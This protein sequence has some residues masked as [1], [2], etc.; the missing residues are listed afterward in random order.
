MNTK[1]G[2]AS[3]RLGIAKFTAAI[4]T[5][6]LFIATA[7]AEVV[8]ST[9]NASDN[10]LN[11]DFCNTGSTNAIGAAECTLRAAIQTLNQGGLPGV[12]DFAIPSDADPGCDAVTKV[13]TLARGAQGAQLPHI[14]VPITISGYSQPEA[15]RNTL[16]VGSNAN[17]VIELKNFSLELDGSDSLVE[18]LVINNFG[19]VWLDSDGN[20]VRGNYIGTD[21]T[22][23]IA[24]PN[25]AGV[26]VRNNAMN[27]VV[28]GLSTEHRNII[29][30]NSGNGI[31]ACQPFCGGNQCGPE[32]G[33]N[34]IVGNYIGVD[35]TGL[36]SLPN[37]GTGVLLGSYN[38]TVRDNVIA[39]NRSSGISLLGG[40]NIVRG[41]YIGVAADGTTALGNRGS[42][43]VVNGNQFDLDDGGGG[44]QIGGLLAED[45]NIIANSE[46]AEGI[47]VGGTERN[48]ANSILSNSIYRNNALGIDLAG[49]L[50]VTD[51]DPGDADTGANN[52]Q[53]FP[54]VTAAAL[55]D[56]ESLI[57]GTLNSTPSTQFTLQFFANT[58]CNNDFAP[59]NHG[60]GETLLGTVSVT[61]DANG[62]VTFSE[63]VGPAPVGQAVVTATAT[64][65]DGNTSEFSE[66]FNGIFAESVDLQISKTPDAD[67]VIVGEGVVYT[68]VVSHA[69]DSKDASGVQITDT[70]PAG[71]TFVSVRV[72]QGPGFCVENAG[73]I[74]CDVGALPDGQSSVIELQVRA[75]TAATISNE[76]SVTSTEPDKDVADNTAST[77]VSVVLG[78][79]TVTDSIAPIDDQ[80]IPFGLLFAQEMRSETVT[81]QNNS[82]ATVTL[83]AVPSDPLAAPFSIPDWQN[84]FGQTLAPFA[85]CTMSVQFAPT[86]PGEAYSSSFEIGFGTSSALVTVSGA[87]AAGISDISVQKDVDKDILSTDQDLATFTLTVSNVGP[88]PADIR[89]TDALPLSQLQIP[90]G[91]EPA[92]DGVGVV[93]RN[94]NEVVWNIS[95]LG[96]GAS[97]TLDIPVQLV[98][99]TGVGCVTN[100]AEA[101]LVDARAADPNGDDN[102]APR[103]IGAIGGC[104]DLS[105]SGFIDEQFD[106]QGWETEALPVFVLTL[107]NLGPTSATD[108]RLFG[109][110]TVPRHPHLD[111]KPPGCNYDNR[112]GDVSCSLGTLLANASTTL[113]FVFE[114]TGGVLGYDVS[115]EHSGTDLEE[116]NDKASDSAY[117]S[118]IGADGICFIATAAYSSYLHPDVQVLRDFRDGYLLTNTAGRA[119]VDWYYETSPRIAEL[120]SQ[121]ATLRWLTRVALTP[122]VYTIKYPWLAVAALISIILL[123]LRR[124]LKSLR[125]VRTE[126]RTAIPQQMLLLCLLA[127]L[128]MAAQAEAGM[129]AGVGGGFSQVEV[130]TFDETEF[131]YKLF[132]GYRLRDELLPFGATL[133]LEAGYIDLGT[134]EGSLL[135]QT[136]E[137]AI[138][139][140]EVY[141]T[142]ILPLSE[143]WEI[144]GKV[145]ALSWDGELTVDGVRSSTDDTDLALGIGISWRTDSALAARAEVEG[146]DLLDGVW[147]WS[148]SA[149]YHFH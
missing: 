95:P 53:N 129:F 94:G 102:S 4:A 59:Q 77:D 108:V 45:G 38:N 58:A 44:N 49:F 34:R 7:T 50:G 83:N 118:Q 79:I 24:D 135:N 55:S 64:D 105:V 54:V 76:A 61:T 51:N 87:S 33:G 72:V 140:F 26:M 133:A 16:A 106:P 112:T 43:I 85:L 65:P 22:G 93:N 90:I 113:R 81:V 122:L 6:A 88:D 70:L 120:I 143:R 146:F 149:I 98:P 124:R 46:I 136:V 28:G 32:C 10:D 127:F 11:D 74:T 9:G 47:T 19:N 66:C 29:S 21:P 131:G 132:A 42:G 56:L 134:T 110:F 69:A 27:N 101:E 119:F 36:A 99:G 137:F 31:T 57:Q 115:V 48:T 103:T 52:L 86:V 142:G 37:S 111:Q 84:C 15:E 126:T 14:A 25:N 39:G 97:A 1:P 30:G 123:L 17:L 68:I 20:T 89:V 109:T 125:R 12:I 96:V 2:L 92:T 91:M 78:D 75:D 141:A 138:D 100:T 104:A 3:S 67:T 107:R 71:L 8:N 116:E 23:L 148:V 60:E 82:T 5:G 80:D 41:N 62:D 114:K 128:P 130:D 145:G 73:E 40:N 144:F 63:T 18:G 35:A 121:Y 147:L 139:G 117:F 13:C